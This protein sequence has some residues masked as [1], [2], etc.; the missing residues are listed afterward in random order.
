MGGYVLYYS[1]VHDANGQYFLFIIVAVHNSN[2]SKLFKLSLVW[3]TT[4]I[5]NQAP[6]GRFSGR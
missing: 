6:I 1:L 2:T 3:A 4:E 5:D